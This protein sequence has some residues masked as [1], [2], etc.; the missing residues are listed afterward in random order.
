MRIQKIKKQLNIIFICG[1]FFFDELALS[2]IFSIIT[3][4][5]KHG[6]ITINL[7]IKIIM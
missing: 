2:M 4:Q 3:P 7:Y 5:T 1:T 6:Y